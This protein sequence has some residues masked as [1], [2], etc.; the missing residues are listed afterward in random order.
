MAVSGAAVAY[1]VAGSVILFSGVKNATLADTV[2]GLLSGNLGNVK[3]IPAKN[4]ATGGTPAPGNTGAGT[5]D[6]AQN[7]T[8]AKSIASQMGLNSWTTGQAWQD[9]VSLWNQESGWN[10][11]A[12]DPTTG[13]YGIPQSLPAVKMATAG[14]DWKTNPETQ[15]I[16]GIG[17]IQ[18]RYGTPVMAWAHEQQNNWY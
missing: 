7:Q 10:Q 2:R 3:A 15:I 5:A 13:A 4:S 6:A 18:G 14:S 12:E 11:Y 9:W 17:Y 1:A 8:L 16:W